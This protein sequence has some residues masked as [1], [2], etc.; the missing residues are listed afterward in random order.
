M[1]GA[2]GTVRLFELIGAGTD[3]EP[4]KKEFLGLFQEGHGL[5]EKRDWVRAHK[6]FI[7]ALKIDGEDK[8]AKLYARRCQKFAADPPSASWDGSFTIPGV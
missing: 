1:E 8:A 5:F 4:D 2:D 6:S 3:L 7:Q